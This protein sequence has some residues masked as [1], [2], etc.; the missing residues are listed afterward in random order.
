MFFRSNILALVGG[1]IKPCYPENKVML[2]DDHQMKCI[3]ELNFKSNVVGV[4]LRKDRIVVILEQKIF[5]YIFNNLKLIEA[6]DTGFNPR[7]LATLNQ[8]GENTILVTPEKNVGEIRITN[9]DKELRPTIKIV[10][11]H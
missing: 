8:S 7:A 4:L 1:G 10:N 2:W 3:G 11:A 6:I 9:Y 5:I